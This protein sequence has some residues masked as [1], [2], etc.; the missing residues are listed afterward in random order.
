MPLT[1]ETVNRKSVK[2]WTV[3]RRTSKPTQ[4][5][6]Q[7]DS[8]VFRSNRRLFPGEECSE[9]VLPVYRITKKMN[10]PPYFRSR[11]GL[12]T[13]LQLSLSVA[14]SLCLSLCSSLCSSFSLSLTARWHASQL[15]QGSRLSHSP[16]ALSLAHSSLTPLQHLQRRDGA[17]LLMNGANFAEIKVMIEMGNGCDKTKTGEIPGIFIR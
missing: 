3:D 4:L 2:P 7:Q 5:V 11:S 10:E 6:E 16:L 15:T 13:G 9:S 8:I 17:G 1:V 12:Y 14:C